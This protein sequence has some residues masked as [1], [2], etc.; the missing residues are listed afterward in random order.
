MQWLKIVSFASFM[1]TGAVALLVTV[2][3]PR[4]FF[5]DPCATFRLPPS[6]VN[7]TYLDQT[8]IEKAWIEP[9]FG[10]GFGKWALAW[11]SIDEYWGWS[12]MQ[13]NTAC[14]TMMTIRIKPCAKTQVRRMNGTL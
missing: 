5:D 2:P 8:T 4:D 6:P 3:S 7:G 9:P 11:T 12:N 14:I 13:V 10:F 1:A